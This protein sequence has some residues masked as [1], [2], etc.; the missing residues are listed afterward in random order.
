[1]IN[2]DDTDKKILELLQNN[3]KLTIREIA[4][5]LHL[6]TTPI[7]DR[8]KRLEKNQIIVK[9]V[10]LLDKSKIGK[11]LTCFLQIS[12]KEHSLAMIKEFTRKIT[13][14]D[15]VMECY[16]IS[17]DFD[18]MVKVV[19]SDMDEFNDFLLSKLAKVPNIYRHSTQFALSCTKYSTAFKNL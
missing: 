7:F 9:N 8:I 3:A 14:F 19:V 13:S 11:K 5:Q 10:V 17:G 15:E 6:S 2:L 18:Y 1:M 16:H 12:I 4:A